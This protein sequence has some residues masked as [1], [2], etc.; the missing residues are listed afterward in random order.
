MTGLTRQLV[1]AVEMVIYTGQTGIPTVSLGKLRFRL[2]S[3]RMLTAFSNRGPQEELLR[4]RQAQVSCIESLHRLYER[5]V[6][7]VDPSQAQVFLIYSMLVEDSVYVEMVHTYIQTQGMTA[8]YAVSMTGES[9][10]SAFSSLEDE[11]MRAR[12]EDVRNVCNFLI[13]TLIGFRETQEH[14][15][16]PVILVDSEFSPEEILDMERENIRA[17][18]AQRGSMSAHAAEL[19]RA[20]GIPAAAQMDIPPILEGRMAVL[21][22]VE[23]KLYIDPDPELFEQLKGRTAACSCCGV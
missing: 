16:E 18:V 3:P 5:A 4:F 2:H 8:E 22:G 10:S 6:K 17:L 12:G 20:L 14:W 15:D 19:A 9:F 13:N 23:G 7:L 21:D 11:Y 1:G